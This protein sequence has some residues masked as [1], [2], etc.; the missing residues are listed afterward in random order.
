MG[1][2]VE[3]LLGTLHTAALS[4]HVYETIGEERI[5]KKCGFDKARMQ[6]LAKFQISDRNAFRNEKCVLL[7]IME[8]DQRKSKIW[9]GNQEASVNE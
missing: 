8:H 3:G 2:I 4:V 9:R 6:G 5:E 7:N 1:E